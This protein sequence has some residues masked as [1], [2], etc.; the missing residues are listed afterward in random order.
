M[1]CRLSRGCGGR[2]PSM[3]RTSR[4]AAARLGSRM[5]TQQMALGLQG[6][7]CSHS[8]MTKLSM[9]RVCH[10]AQG[11]TGEARCWP[12]NAQWS[13]IA[14]AFGSGFGRALCIADSPLA[15]CA[16]LTCRLQCRQERQSGNSKPHYKVEPEIVAELYRRWVMPLNKEVQ[17]QYLLRRL[18][19]P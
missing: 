18:E 2:Q 16:K 7:C 11:V 6:A 19:A 8:I 3:G 14:W 9:H 12:Q 17:I 1:E 5:A 13:S 4:A 15:V 10:I